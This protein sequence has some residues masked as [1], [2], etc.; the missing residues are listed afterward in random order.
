[1]KNSRTASFQ[2]TDL[3]ALSD[4]D[5]SE[6]KSTCLTVWVDC[7]FMQVALCP[8][9]AN[10]KT[11]YLNPI[12]V[13]KASDVMNNFENLRSA[14]AAKG[15]QIGFATMSF[16]GPVSQD[17]VIITNWLCEARERVIHF[18]NLPF[19]LFPLDRR[20]F[21]NDLEAA[22]YGIVARFING[23]LPKIFKVLWQADP[24]APFLANL[25]GNSLVIWI[26]GGL[27]VSFI[28]RIE[29]AD[30]NCVVSS[31]GSHQQ[32]N[33]LPPWHPD[34]EKD[35]EIQRFFS[36]KLH[37]EA[38]QAEW[39]DFGSIGGL[40]LA[41]QFACRCAG[42]ELKNN[43]RYDE[44]RN[45]A[46]ANDK[47]ALE[48]FKIHYTYIFRCIQSLCLTIRCKRVFV[49]SEE[50][51]KNYP[52]VTNMAKILYTIFTDHP[53]SSWLKDIDI[54]TQYSSSSFALSGGL[55]ISKIF[56]LSHQSESHFD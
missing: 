16:A 39:E 8:A 23:S 15:A 5:D 38:H 17:H 44:I 45:L 1:M 19:D 10:K 11:I 53:R 49:I 3:K 24:K 22:S 42:I 56:A 12:K 20:Q 54:Y 2:D 46:L 48:A 7:S 30:Y 43:L 28:S 32:A 29:T 50:H 27:G 31:E 9:N 51:V 6:R 4:W 41:Y 34:F 55:F 21:M 14:L 40:E 25:D 18:S 52:L 37:G 36:Q 13:N 35:R 33:C 26:G 47:N